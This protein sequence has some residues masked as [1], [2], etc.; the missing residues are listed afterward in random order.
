MAYGSLDTKHVAQ[1]L[2]LG[3]GEELIKSLNPSV[4]ASTATISGGA[5]F[6]AVAEFRYELGPTCIQ[7]VFST[8]LHLTTGSSLFVPSC[9]SFGARYI[10]LMIP[11]D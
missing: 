4:R 10:Q 6:V 5:V 1:S 7:K 11:G 9:T 8:I 3:V 2:L